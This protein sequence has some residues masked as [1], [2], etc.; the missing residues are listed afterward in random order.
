MPTHS[1]LRAKI[2]EVTEAFQEAQV[3][4]NAELMHYYN[5]EL[6]VYLIRLADVIGNPTADRGTD[7]GEL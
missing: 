7:S 3:N 4:G 6:V 5:R 1:I 2:R